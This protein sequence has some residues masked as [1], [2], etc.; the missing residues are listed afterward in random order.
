MWLPRS[1]YYYR[2]RAVLVGLDDGK[3][4]ALIRDIQDEFAGYGYRRVTLELRARG[5]IVNHKHVA[6][7]MRE[8]DLHIKPPRRFVRTG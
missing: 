1:T 6:R 4:V 3:L 2:S 8:H 7:L 5:Y